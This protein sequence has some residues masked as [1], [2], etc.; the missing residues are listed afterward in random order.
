MCGEVPCGKG[1]GSFVLALVDCF[2][3]DPVVRGDRHPIFCVNTK[4]IGDSVDVV[5][6]A[7][8]LNGDGN[9]FV[10]KA[11]LMQSINV[12]GAHGSGSFG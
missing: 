2:L 4:P 5:E 1:R 12:S 11:R 6:V 8:H 3:A 7:N 9:F 10:S